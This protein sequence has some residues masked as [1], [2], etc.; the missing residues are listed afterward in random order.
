MKVKFKMRIE[1]MCWEF[2]EMLKEVINEGNE[3]RKKGR[4]E[5]ERY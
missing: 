5:R 1:S 3:R 4:R 2:G